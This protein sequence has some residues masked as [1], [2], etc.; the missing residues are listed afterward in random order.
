M[1]K[2][3]TRAGNRNLE[4]AKRARKDEFYTQ[5][6]D[7]ANELKHYKAHFRGKSVLCNCDDPRESQF[8]KYF[9]QNFEIFGLKR[10]VA[11]C[12]KSQDKDL[13][14]QNDSEKAIYQIYEGD[15]NGNLQVDDSEV[16]IHEFKG[17]GDFRSDEA[18]ALLEQADI[19][20]T[21]PP[22]SLF[23]EYIA[24]LVKYKKKFLVLGNKNAIT[25]SEIFPFFKENKIWVGVM[26]MTREIYFDVPQEYI[27]EGL[28]LKKD[29]TIVKYDGKYKARSPSIWFTNLEHKKRHEK[30]PL[31]KHYTPEEYPKYDNYDAIEV[32]KTAD[33]PQDYDGVMG[34]PITFMDKYNPD[35]F[36]ILGNEE[37]LGVPKGRGYLNG[38]RLYGR[39]FIRR[40]G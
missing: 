26:P 39:I 1:A 4:D 25:Y 16:G 14:S 40:K 6:A 28:R 31:Y 18:I 21:N 9:T 29:R 10:L 36:E 35:Q 19:V 2:R 38:K 3:D 15:K 34:V 13:F 5:M 20:V 8:F 33:I 30:L 24:L 11:T 27:D 7:I 12:Y 32:S 22:F 23:R 37:D 17:D